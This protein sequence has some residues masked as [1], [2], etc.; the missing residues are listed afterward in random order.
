[1]GPAIEG[2]SDEYRNPVHTYQTNNSSGYIVVLT[3]KGPGGKESVDKV[4]VTVLSCSEAANVELSEAKLAIQ[5]CIKAAGRTL[6]APVPAWDGAHGMVTAGGIDAADYLRLWDT[7]KATY[8]VRQDG[9]IEE[10]IDVSWGCIKWAIS[11]TGMRWMAI[12]L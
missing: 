9:V 5:S 3:V 8:R 7:F 4:A 10:G 2:S 11:I 1:D 6:D 12:E